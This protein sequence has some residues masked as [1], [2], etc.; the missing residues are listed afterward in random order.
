[1]KLLLS[2]AQWHKQ[3]KYFAYY[4]LANGLIAALCICWLLTQIESLSGLSLLAYIG[5]LGLAGFISYCGYVTLKQPPRGLKLSRLSLI[6]QL[7]GFAID[8]FAFHFFA[9]P[10]LALSLN[11]T[12]G[13]LFNLNANLAGLSFDITDTSTEVLLSINVVAMLLFFRTTFWLNEWH[14][15]S[16]LT[17]S[18]AQPIA[19]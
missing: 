18:S 9:G 6:A 11:L 19:D 13:V 5:C 15:R 2:E 12:N 10:Y 4:Q 16:G 1:M 3:V 17:E 14:T 8:G 7:I